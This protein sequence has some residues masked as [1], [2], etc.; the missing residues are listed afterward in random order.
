M[1]I[2]NETDKALARLGPALVET[3]AE[4]E[5]AKA[6]IAN[7]QKALETSQVK[8]LDL[9]QRLTDADKIM[10]DKEA[11]INKQS[12]QEAAAKR[13]VVPDMPE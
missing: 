9:Q 2:L 3:D 6:E 4:C 5:N 12:Q 7:L 8:V 1:I 10:A 11:L 13:W